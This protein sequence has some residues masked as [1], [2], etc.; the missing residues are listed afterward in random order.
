MQNNFTKVFT[1]VAQCDIM[2]SDVKSGNKNP[3]SKTFKKFTKYF[4]KRSAV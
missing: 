4:T 3:H 1:G 2:I